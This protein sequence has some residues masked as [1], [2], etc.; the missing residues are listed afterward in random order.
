MLSLFILA[1]CFV[2]SITFDSHPE[3]INFL[4]IGLLAVLFIISI[5]LKSDIN[6]RSLLC[7]ILVLALLEFIFELFLMSKLTGISYYFAYLE[8]IMF[9]IFC[10]KVF[11]IRPYLARLVIND[12]QKKQIKPL[13]IEGHLL[14]IFK[15]ILLPLEMIMLFEFT[16]YDFKVLDSSFFYDNYEV[17]KNIALAIFF[18]VLYYGVIFYN[19]RGSKAP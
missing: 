11:V 13:L 14:R 6:V 1:L 16:L 5:S 4:F 19:K 18:A 12:K 17:L 10:Y 7:L 2:V 8:K 3:Y 15:Y 9:V